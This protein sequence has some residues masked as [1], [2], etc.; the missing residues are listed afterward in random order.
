MTQEAKE[1]RLKEAASE[2]YGQISEED[3]NAKMAEIRRNPRKFIRYGD[4]AESILQNKIMQEI[5]EEQKISVLEEIMQTQIEQT[6][7]R[8]NCYL[9]LRAMM[10]FDQILFEYYRLGRLAKHEMIKAEA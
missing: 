8:E 10:A 3:F 7:E 2:I 5:R 1:Q 6:K 9:F 4:F